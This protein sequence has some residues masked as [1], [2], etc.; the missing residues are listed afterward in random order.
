MSVSNKLINT[1]IDNFGV[2]YIIEIHTHRHAGPTQ[3]IRVCT[4]FQRGSGSVKKRGT[5]F[6]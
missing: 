2:D 6:D 4:D 5:N 3:N 1:S